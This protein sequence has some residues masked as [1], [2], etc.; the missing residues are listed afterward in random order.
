MRTKAVQ[1]EKKVPNKPEKDSSNK[2]KGVAKIG[3]ASSKAAAAKDDAFDEFDDD[4]DEDENSQPAV[5][6]INQ[7]TETLPK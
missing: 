3:I 4:E 7:R 5:K 1:E 6:F 2:A